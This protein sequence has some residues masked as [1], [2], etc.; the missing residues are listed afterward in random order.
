MENQ[1]IGERLSQIEQKVDTYHETKGIIKLTP[2]NNAKT[3]LE[4]ES[5][6]M[7][8]LNEQE[9]CEA[10]I[11]LNQYSAF[12]QESYNKE[13]S[14]VNWAT[15]EM[16]RVSAPQLKQYA[17]KFQSYEE[18]CNLVIAGDEH[19]SEL[20]RVRMWAQQL[21]DRLN[22]MAQRVDAIAKSYLAL[23]QSKRKSQ[24]VER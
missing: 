12:L 15:S 1:N 24:Y 7:R 17:G 8:G 14:R 20:D 4:L 2:K 3:Y 21:A 19:V 18:K 11:V 9:C 22:F 6:A 10:S 23:A 13:L 5:N 16:K